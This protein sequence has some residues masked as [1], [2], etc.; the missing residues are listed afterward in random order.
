MHVDL[1]LGLRARDSVQLDL[2]V[3]AC[4]DKCRVCCVGN[5]PTMIDQ[6]CWS[7]V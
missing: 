5:N 7:M 4:L 6:S 3:V 1:E 2:E